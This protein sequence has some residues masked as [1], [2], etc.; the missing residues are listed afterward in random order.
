NK[1]TIRLKR[2]IDELMDFRKLQFDKIPLNIST[3]NINSLIEESTDYFKEEAN[4]RNIVLSIEL[5]K[6]LPNVTAD[7][8]K[9]EKILFNILS[10]AFKSTPNNGIITVAVAR[11]EKHIFKLIDSNIP[12]EALEMS[13]ED[14]G[15]GIHPN[16]LGKIFNR[17]YQIK[18]RNEQYY[19]GTGIGLEVV[20]SFVELHRGDIE[21]ESER[22][23]GT[24]F[25]ILLPM[26]KDLYEPSEIKLTEELTKPKNELPEV[27][28][29]E[30]GE[31]HYKKMLLIVEDNLEL[32]SYMKQEL[33]ADYKVIVAENGVE[34][35]EKAQ[36]YIPDV[37]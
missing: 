24:K 5:E 30:N 29:A 13:I 3:F 8:G 16:E 9:L 23:V 17:F 7:K 35:L 10:N 26:D 6:N 21:I 1:N 28:V 11:K 22:G 4:Q 31:G 20:Q 33:D 34:G 18:E 27:D 15:I 32:R 14:T 12:L 19:S 37:V 36:K 25:K 2:L